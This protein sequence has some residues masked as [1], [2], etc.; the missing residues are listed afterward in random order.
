MLCLP[1]VG[2]AQR[3]AC[4]A[5]VHVLHIGMLIMPAFKP[6]A[7]TELPSGLSVVP[8]PAGGEGCSLEGGCASCPYMKMNSLAALQTGQSRANKGPSC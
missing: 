2:A 7:Q 1:T 5:T 4:C 8:G 3:A 6:S